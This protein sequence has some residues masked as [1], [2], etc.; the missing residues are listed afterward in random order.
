MLRLLGIAI[1]ATVLG[2]G[3]F[4]GAPSNTEAADL[5]TFLAEVEEAGQAAAPAR[6]DFRVRVQVQGASERRYEGAVAYTGANVYVEMG[7]P[8]V[9]ARMR[10][11][12]TEALVGAAV[13]EEWKRGTAYDALG[14]TSLIADDFRPFRVATLKT[15]QIVSETKQT[16]LVSGA[17]AEPSPWVL[18]VHLFDRDKLR[19]VRTQY[20][21]RTISNMVR[22]RRDGDHARVGSVW[23]PRRIEIEDY[24]VGTSTTVELDWQPSPTLPA[25]LFDAGAGATP[26]LRKQP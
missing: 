14:D 10:G 2:T 4:F 22:M 1:M 17:P 21:E 3:S 5:S 26:S 6:A 12:E 25:G 8:M 19:P 15:P 18:V 11:E 16:I 23:R 9:R 13:G 7:E 24:R 20:Y